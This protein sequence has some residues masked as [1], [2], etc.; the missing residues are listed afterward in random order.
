[1][2]NFLLILN[3]TQK[4]HTNEKANDNMLSHDVA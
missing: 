2:A 1:M 4:P 3:Y